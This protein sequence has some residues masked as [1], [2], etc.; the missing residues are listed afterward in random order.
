M[1]SISNN[2]PPTATSENSDIQYKALIIFSREP[3]MDLDKSQM[4]EE[5]ERIIKVTKSLR[6]SERID[7]ISEPFFE[8][9]KFTVGAWHHWY[10]EHLNDSNII[11]IICSPTLKQIL[12]NKESGAIY[13]ESFQRFSTTELFTQLESYHKYDKCI[14]VFLERNVDKSL[15]PGYIK[16]PD[17]ISCFHLANPLDTKELG[18]IIRGDTVQPKVQ[19]IREGKN[20]FSRVSR[21]SQRRGVLGASNKQDSKASNYVKEG[22]LIFCTKQCSIRQQLFCR[23][24]YKSVSFFLTPDAKQPSFEVPLASIQTIM[25]YG[26]MFSSQSSSKLNPVPCLLLTTSDGMEYYIGLDVI[27]RDELI[28]FSKD[29]VKPGDVFNLQ[30][31]KEKEWA[32][33]G[34][35]LSSMVEWENEFHALLMP[36]TLETE[37]EQ[38]HATGQVSKGASKEPPPPVVSN[39]SEF[40]AFRPARRPKFGGMHKHQMRGSFKVPKSTSDASIKTETLDISLFY[41]VFHQDILGSG[42]FGTVFG[43][44]NRKSGRLVAVKAIEK[45]QFP[46]DEKQALLNE[47]LFLQGIS[48]PGIVGLE[49]VFENWKMLFVVMERLAGDMLELILTQPIGRLD[50][51]NTKTIIYQILIAL[52]Y[53]HKHDAVHCDLKPENVLLVSKEIPYQIKL[54]DF[55]Y[56][57]MINTEQFRRSLVGTPAYVAP[58]VLDSSGY[59]RAL[60]MWSSGVITYVSLSGT[61]PFNEDEDIKSQVSNQEFMYPS[62]PWKLIS[63]TAIDLVN[64]LMEVSIRKR[65]NVSRALQ[66]PWFVDKDMWLK[67]KQLESRVGYRYLTTEKQDKEF[68][69]IPENK[70]V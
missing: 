53:L 70:A 54:C 25:P 3:D 32:E 2:L 45:T 26:A 6:E 28:H 60:D 36:F 68:Q 56:A 38:S 9:N 58:E 18:R 69:A 43:G 41:Q 23:L 33:F 50:E 48:H 47:V 24:S 17:S 31:L 39:K 46:I 16:D 52:R 29:P 7:A 15:L 37:Q 59:N 5:K 65:Y 19:N 51:F 49:K 34:I 12:M 22:W 61:F 35:G 20:N 57:R 11:L 63:P 14:Y 8:S 21:I 30:S 55:G 42:Q 40:I 1:A 44:V 66:H 27:S 67:L 62:H 4:K 64:N 10:S 13:E